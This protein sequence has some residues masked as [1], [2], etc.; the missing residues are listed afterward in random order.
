MKNALIQEY[1]SRMTPTDVNN[2]ALNN[3]IVLKDDELTLVYN[4][5]IKNWRTIV[6]GNPRSILDDLK[7][8]LDNV[9]YQKIE[10]LYTRFKNRYL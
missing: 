10:T 5:I 4:H 7:K 1:I 3:G 9:T 6:Y 8:N 2:F